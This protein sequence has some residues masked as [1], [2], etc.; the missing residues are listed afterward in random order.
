MASRSD[1]PK[2]LPHLFHNIALDCPQLSILHKPV[3]IY[4]L[5]SPHTMRSEPER[6]RCAQDVL[7]TGRVPQF[8]TFGFEG[9]M[10]SRLLLLFFCYFR[11]DSRR[12]THFLT[13]FHFST[14]CRGITSMIIIFVSPFVGGCFSSSFRIRLSNLVLSCRV[15]LYAAGGCVRV[16]ISN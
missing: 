8:F 13:R 9:V 2:S 3:Y 4:L 12:F 10:G 7:L 16:K 15:E 6:P 14:V 1:S 11:V 5:I